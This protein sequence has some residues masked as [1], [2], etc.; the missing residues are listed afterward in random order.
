MY[1]VHYSHE[2]CQHRNAESERYRTELGAREQVRI[3]NGLIHEDG[4]CATIRQLPE[5]ID[6]ESE[7]RA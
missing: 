5:S 4:D 7:V 6:Y 2:D 3:H 1:S